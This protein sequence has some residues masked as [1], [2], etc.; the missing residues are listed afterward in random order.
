MIMV[1]VD[2]LIFYEFEEVINFLV[3]ILDVVI[4]SRSD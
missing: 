2:E 3:E 1:L 4:I